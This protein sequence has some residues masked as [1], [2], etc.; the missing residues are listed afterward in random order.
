MAIDN[1]LMHYLAS[2][3]TH[4]NKCIYTS[5]RPK[6]RH[7]KRDTAYLVAGYSKV[8]ID[9]VWETFIKFVSVGRDNFGEE[10]HRRPNDF[11]GFDVFEGVC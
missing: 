2:R 7:I 10:F 5:G 8:K 3:P 6:I 11:G 1:D 9:G 4:G